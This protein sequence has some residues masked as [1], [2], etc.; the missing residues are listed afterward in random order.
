MLIEPFHVSPGPPAL[1]GRCRMFASDADGIHAPW[2]QGQDGFETEVACPVGNE[3]VHI[4]ESLAWRCARVVSLRT[5]RRRQISGLT[6][7]RTMRS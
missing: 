6:S 1:L 5:S 3:V 2:R 7:R 4:L